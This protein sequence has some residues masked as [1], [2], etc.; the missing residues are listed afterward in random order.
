MEETPQDDTP[1]APPNKGDWSEQDIE[2]LRKMIG[3]KRDV[4]DGAIPAVV[5]VV[6]NAIWSLTPAAIAA[7][8]YGLGTALYRVV[9]K[10]DAKRA[11]IG[12]LGLA[13]AVGIALRTGSASS[14][15]L[16]GVVIGILFGAMTLL[17]VALKQPT[18]VMFAVA[19]EKKPAEYYKRP[20]VLRAHMLI[21]TVWGL[22]FLG[23]ALLRAFFIANEQTELLGASAIV[24]GYPVTLGL[25]AVTV[26]YLRRIS[27]KIEQA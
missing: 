18:S 13:I 8:A 22:V 3:G 23:R 19:L 26:V 6:V 9:R 14:Y 15:F 11:L 27:A 25:A 17:T 4:A 12:L 10:Q 1:V 21:T 5:F 2:R 7:G 16:P 20:D 24:L